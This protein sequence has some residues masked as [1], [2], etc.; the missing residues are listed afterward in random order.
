MNTE[1][2][3]RENKQEYSD[4]KVSKPTGEVLEAMRKVVEAQYL[5]ESLEHIEKPTVDKIDNH[6]YAVRDMLDDE[7]IHHISM[8]K[9]EINHSYETI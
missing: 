3:K 6:L 8:H 7:L 5:I 9:G 1:Q 4:I 2:N